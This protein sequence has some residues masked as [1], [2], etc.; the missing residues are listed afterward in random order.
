MAWAIDGP[1]LEKKLLVHLLLT[2][3]LGLF[4]LRPP[5]AGLRRR[6]TGSQ[7][8]WRNS[9][10]HRTLIL[11]RRRDEIPYLLKYAGIAPWRLHNE[12]K[13]RLVLALLIIGSQ[14]GTNGLH[15][16]SFSIQQ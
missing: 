6:L 15:A 8:W 11:H 7:S 14:A 16:L 9:C 5:A 2:S 3:A 10:R 13:Q 12:V 1:G 4:R